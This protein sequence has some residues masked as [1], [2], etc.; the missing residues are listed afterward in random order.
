MFAE[1]LVKCPILATWLGGIPKQFPRFP[2]PNSTCP[3]LFVAFPGIHITLRLCPPFW[4][5]GYQIAVVENHLGSLLHF[6]LN[7]AF[8]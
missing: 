7:I 1:W 6:W 4:G 5:G 8:W 3:I 2:C